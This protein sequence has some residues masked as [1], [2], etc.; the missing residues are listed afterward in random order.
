MNPLGRI[1]LTLIMLFVGYFF[2][3]FAWV[4]LL[5]G[6]ILLILL[7]AYLSHKSKIIIAQMSVIFL[8]LSTFIMTPFSHAL[9]DILKLGNSGSYYIFGTILVF[10]IIWI[11]RIVKLN[12]L[13]ENGSNTQSIP[14]LLETFNQNYPFLIVSLLVV[15]LI[16]PTLDLDFSYGGDEHYHAMSIVISQHLLITLFESP[17][18]FLC[19]ISAVLLICITYKYKKIKDNPTVS[20]VLITISIISFGVSWFITH[21]NIKFDNLSLERALRYPCSEPWISAILGF[22][23]F[24]YLR[25]YK[26]NGAG[27]INDFGTMRLL[28]SLSYLLAGFLTYRSLLHTI[29]SYVSAV[30]TLI[31]LTTPILLYESTLLYLEMP[32]VAALLIVLLDSEKILS[33]PPNELKNRISFYALVSL[34]FLKESG[35]VIVIT[36]IILR[37]LFRL[38]INKSNE[39]NQKLLKGEFTIRLISVLGGLLYLVARAFT[40]YRPYNFHPNN[41]LNFDLWGKG[42]FQLLQ[43][44]HILVIPLILSV[45]IYIYKKTKYVVTSLVVFSVLWFFFFLEDPKWVGLARFNLLFAPSIIVSGLYIL[46]HL[47]YKTKKIYLYVF[48]FISLVLNVINIPFEMTGYRKDWGGSGERWYNWSQCL[49]DIKKENE[50]AKIIVANM[51][52]KYG[53]GLVFAKLNW[54]PALREMKPVVL[55]NEVEDFKATLS[56]FEG[57]DADYFIYRYETL[58][59][60]NNSDIGEL[61][62]QYRVCLFGKYPSATGGLL[63]LKKLI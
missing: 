1:Y 13:I 29:G 23:D 26:V 43:Q 55:E 30:I 17:I 49:S 61:I 5:F 31:F 10:A 63:V 35:I 28:P 54:A 46:A 33:A 22:L 2:I 45:F 50:Q 38:K 20:T 48:I 16:R 12:D 41:L 36:L 58:F 53:F 34:Q 8:F 6:L 7:N 11:L 47:Y 51:Q 32:L 56:M 44:Y 39:S 21:T 3:P 57:S 24:S 25:D 4:K 14:N 59:E 9:A 15:L 62:K 18:P 27:A 42:L 40:P 19:I 37:L 52:Y 60:K